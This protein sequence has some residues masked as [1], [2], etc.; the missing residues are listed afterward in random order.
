MTVHFRVHHR[1]HCS[2]GQSTSQNGLVVHLPHAH[3]ALPPAVCRPR[4]RTEADLTLLL[5]CRSPGRGLHLSDTLHPQRIGIACGMSTQLHL[6]THSTGSRPVCNVGPHSGG[7]VAAEIMQSRL[8]M[9]TSLPAGPLN[10]FPPTSWVQV[11]C[12]PS[13]LAHP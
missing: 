2:I 1:G 8:T 13:R 5:A 6:C 7:L 12:K 11:Q 9:G 10:R 4:P 3:C